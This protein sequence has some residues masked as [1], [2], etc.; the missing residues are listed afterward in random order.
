LVW[1]R[2]PESNGKYEDAIKLY[3]LAGFYDHVLILVTKQMGRVLTQTGPDRATLVE[4]A[5]FVKTKYEAEIREPRKFEAFSRQVS[6]SNY[7][8]FVLLLGLATF[9]DLYRTGSFNKALEKIK[10]LDMLPFESR[11]LEEKVNSFKHYSD[12]I[13]RN[14]AEV[15]LAAMECLLRIY[16][17]YRSTGGGMDPAREGFLAGLKQEA[18]TLI[19]FSGMIQFRMPGNA[20]ASLVRMEVSMA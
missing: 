8:S 15:L 10:E 14:F 11:F 5:K 1:L 18:K 9:F 4:L 6:D 17:A 7:R 19:M 20:H 2:R 13:R 3:D 12:S 16:N